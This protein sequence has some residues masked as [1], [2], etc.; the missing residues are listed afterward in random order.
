MASSLLASGSHPQ[1]D[2]RR[3]RG[4]RSRAQV[5]ERA[6]HVA[7]V[8]GLG[9]LSFGGLAADV[10]ASKA[11]LQTLF[12]T[13]EQLQLAVIEHARRLFV[14]A[15]I[16]PSRSAPQ[17]TPRLRALLDRW[18]EYAEAPLFEGGC[19]RAANMAAFDSSPGPVRDLLFAHQA[20]WLECLTVEL[21]HV[22]KRSKAD[23]AT[24]AF[25]LDAILCATNTSLRLGDPDAVRRM[26]RLVEEVL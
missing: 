7:S 2:G 26:R 5:L 19:F 1:P 13:K 9:G 8:R 24:T 12:G 16:E 18:V 21:R 20:E 17:G 15:V 23:A 4:D 10:G 22:G 14:G 6:V 25:H 3:V 11:G